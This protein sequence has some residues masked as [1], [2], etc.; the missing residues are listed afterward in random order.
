MKYFIVALT[1]VLVTFCVIAYLFFSSPGISIG[2]R[3]NF[4]TKGGE[5]T[6]T[7]ITA[8]GTDFEDMERA[9]QDFKADAPSR[10]NLKLYRTTAKNYLKIGKWAMYHLKPEWS[11]EYLPGRKRG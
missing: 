6:Y 1:S 9:F 10:N 8:K 11:Y 5:F 4:Q 7:I 2:E 3:I